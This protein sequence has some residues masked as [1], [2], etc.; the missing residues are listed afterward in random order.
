MENILNI[1]V[2]TLSLSVKSGRI[3]SAEH[4]ARTVRLL[5]ALLMHH[6]MTTL[7]KIAELNTKM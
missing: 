3:I 6:I 1:W 4:G 2:L 7:K 5:Q